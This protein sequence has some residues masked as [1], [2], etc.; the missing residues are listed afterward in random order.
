M[1]FFTF[2]LSI[3]CLGA[4]VTCSLRLPRKL[5]PLVNPEQLEE[6]DQLTSFSEVSVDTHTSV[7]AEKTD[8]VSSNDGHGVFF[9]PPVQGS[10]MVKSENISA[11]N[12]LTDVFITLPEQNMTMSSLVET[13][14][15][16]KNKNKRRKNKS[17]A[18]SGYELSDTLKKLYKNKLG[19]VPT[20]HG[21][22]SV[23][24]APVVSESSNYQS[25][26]QNLLLAG[27]YQTNNNK[28]KNWQD[29]HKEE[30]HSNKK[31]H[32]SWKA[33]QGKSN[34]DEDFFEKKDD[35]WCDTTME[36]AGV[37]GCW[38]LAIRVGMVGSDHLQ[39]INKDKQL[40][41]ASS[42]PQPDDKMM[43]P[44]VNLLEIPLG[45]ERWHEWTSPDGYIGPLATDTDFI[46]L[47][48]K[49]VS[50]E[51]LQAQN[52]AAASTLSTMNKNIYDSVTKAI[53]EQT[54]QNAALM[55]QKTEEMQAA[56]AA[57]TQASH[58]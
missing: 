23:A 29:K 42:N 34:E 54:A 49:Q 17:P 56:M 37:S 10:P 26:D 7:H 50:P 3:A 9:F 57:A 4:S 28:H 38:D 14:R 16:H 41:C 11:N 24:V 2:V 36:D 31:K 18:T 19:K 15:R 21:S 32:S 13:A 39:I 1:K 5:S 25:S 51:D 55:K 53:A 12:T 44:C 40:P 58:V 33:K 47:S 8:L 52:D 43:Y 27:E 48:S 45:D 30:K 35:G 6:S 46:N 22:A 20:I